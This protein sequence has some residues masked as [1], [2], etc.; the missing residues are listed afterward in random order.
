MT[1]RVVVERR[2]GREMAALLIDGELEDFL[3]DPVGGNEFAHGAVFRAVV[4]RSL[5]SQGGAVARL[6]GGQRAFIRGGGGLAA[7][8]TALVQISSYAESGKAIPAT[9]NVRFK[10]RFAIS[11]VNRP[12]TNLARSISSTQRRAYLANFAKTLCREAP[13]NVGLIL[14]SAAADADD[15]EIAADIELVL[16]EADIALSGASGNSPK[17]LLPGPRASEIA[18]RDWFRTNALNLYAEGFDN[19][20]IW[21]LLDKYRGDKFEMQNGSL[22]YIQ[23]TKAIV[24]VDV[25]TGGDHSTR[26]GLKAN[27]NAARIL[28]RILRIKGL[29]GQIVVDFA[30]APKNTR[31]SIVDA[32]RNS[33]RHDLVETSL[34]GWTPLGN[35]ELQRKRLR[36]PLS[37]S[38]PE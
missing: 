31:D 13:E 24:A 14:R 12:G 5:K 20:G 10:R 1:R 35:F 33:L 4:D 9:Q 36:F 38:W 26:S 6:P 16:G 21:E 17:M 27:L 25:N 19:F 2:A 28:P 3:I 37:E 11:V 18:R 7:G 32:L 22:M 15:E 23:E 29:G 34:A 30:P 8:S